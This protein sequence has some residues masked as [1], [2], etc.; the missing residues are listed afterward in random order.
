MI[1]F[2]ENEIYLSDFTLSQVVKRKERYFK[3]VGVKN[4]LA[5]E[6]YM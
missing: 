3:I 5:P 1:D 2:K 6:F 4:Y